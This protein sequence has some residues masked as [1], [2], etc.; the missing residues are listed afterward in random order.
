V[1]GA[2]SLVTFAAL[3]LV[4][5]AAASRGI[6]STVVKS[7]L[8]DRRGHEKNGFENPPLQRKRQPPRQ[9]SRSSGGKS[10]PPVVWF[11]H[12]SLGLQWRSYTSAFGAR[13]T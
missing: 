9:V 10:G 13:G 3:G 2:G 12:S 5:S 7:G 6:A 8:A 11:H 4:E 1:L